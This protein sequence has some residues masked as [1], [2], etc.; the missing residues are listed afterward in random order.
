MVTFRAS[1]IVAIGFPITDSVGQKH[2]TR[3]SNGCMVAALRAV[4]AINTRENQRRSWTRFLNR[5]EA[6]L[7]AA[8]SAAAYVLGSICCVCSG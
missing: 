8:A 6:L 5:V 3:A 1:A 7:Y 4:K 2:P